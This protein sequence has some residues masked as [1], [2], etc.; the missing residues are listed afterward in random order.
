MESRG[1]EEAWSAVLLRSTRSSRLCFSRYRQ[2]GIGAALE[3]SAAG[4]HAWG[5]FGDS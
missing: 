2:K 1:E 3:V 4:A 5:V